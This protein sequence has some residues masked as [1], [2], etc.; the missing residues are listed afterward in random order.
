MHIMHNTL[1]YGYSMH[2]MHIMDT[3]LVY[4]YYAYYLRAYVIGSTRVS[5]LLLTC[6]NKKRGHVCPTQTLSPDSPCD[7]STTRSY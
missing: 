5:I 4:A 6:P 7:L 3:T 2:N 1:G